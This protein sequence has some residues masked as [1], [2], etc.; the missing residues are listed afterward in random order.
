MVGV[1]RLV[2]P[3]A[4]VL[5]TDDIVGRPASGSLAG[6]ATVRIAGGEEDRDRGVC[7]PDRFDGAERPGSVPGGDADDSIEVV[8]NERLDCRLDRRDDGDVDVTERLLGG[9]CLGGLRSDRENASG[10]RLTSQVIGTM[11]LEL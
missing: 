2:D 5:G 11:W 8:V 7:R 6:Q 4:E 9:L 1:D 3:V 10:V